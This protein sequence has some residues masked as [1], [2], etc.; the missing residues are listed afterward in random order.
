MASRFRCHAR[1]G[2]T[3]IADHAGGSLAGKLFSD[4]SSTAS[5]TSGRG[6][7]GPTTPLDRE[8]LA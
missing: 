7:G 4:A 8:S 1:G 2:P 3:R 5:G 6:A